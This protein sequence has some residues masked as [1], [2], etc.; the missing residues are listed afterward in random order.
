MILILQKSKID[1]GRSRRLPDFDKQRSEFFPRIVAIAPKCCNPSFN[2]VPLPEQP[3]FYISWEQARRFPARK[4]IFNLKTKCQD[5]L[6][7][8]FLISDF[9]VSYI[10]KESNTARSGYKEQLPE[11]K[12][13]HFGEALYGSDKEFKARANE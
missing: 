2:G 11:Y 6:S 8:F 12:T 13:S 7:G 9:L 5:V 1:M 4:E 3:M 10:T